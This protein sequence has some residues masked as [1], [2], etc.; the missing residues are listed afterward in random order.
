VLEFSERI[1]PSFVEVRAIDDFRD[2]L[3]PAAA[4]SSS[5][6]LLNVAE[7][8]RSISESVAGHIA[9]LLTIRLTMYISTLPVPAVRNALPDTADYYFALFERDLPIADES[10]QRVYGQLPGLVQPLQQPNDPNLGVLRPL[11]R[12]QLRVE[13]HNWG[14]L[15]EQWGNRLAP[16]PTRPVFR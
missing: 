11:T 10:M 9:P 6:T 15:E 1:V 8:L 12:V 5:Q 13:Q 3:L 16:A 2:H 14:T 7:E 4:V